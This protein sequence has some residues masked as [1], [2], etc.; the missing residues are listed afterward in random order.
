MLELLCE[1]EGGRDPPPSTLRSG[2]EAVEERMG[3][4]GKPDPVSAL[5]S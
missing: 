3:V 4:P 1:G 2:D 5:V